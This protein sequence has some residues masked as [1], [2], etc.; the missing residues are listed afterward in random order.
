MAAGIQLNA[1]KYTYY[2]GAP[3]SRSGLCTRIVCSSI[4][5]QW[6]K[7]GADAI[8]GMTQSWTH[9]SEILGCRFP[10]ECFVFPSRTEGFEIRKKSGTWEPPSSCSSQK[11]RGD[12]STLGRAPGWR[13]CPSRCRSSC[14]IRQQ[15]PSG[16]GTWQAAS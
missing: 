9:P 11:H 2:T 5:R 16:R 8:L 6:T 12:S 3:G 14:S 10:R 15:G 13:Q 7:T 4:T 1:R